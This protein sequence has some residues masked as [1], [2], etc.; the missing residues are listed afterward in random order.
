MLNEELLKLVAVEKDE[1]NAKKMAKTILNKH[2][3]DILVP[4]LQNGQSDSRDCKNVLKLL[5]TIVTISLSTFG[6][7]ILARLDIHNDVLKAMSKNQNRKDIFLNFFLSF[8]MESDNKIIEL[9]VQKSVWFFQTIVTNFRNY[10]DFRINILLMKLKENFLQNRN[11]SKSL[12]IQFFSRDFILQLLQID[13]PQCLDTVSDFL[14]IL[15]TTN[16]GVGFVFQN[17]VHNFYKKNTILKTILIRNR[18]LF[19]Q[20]WNNKLLSRFLLSVSLNCLDLTKDILLL[21]ESNFKQFDDHFFEINRF[22]CNFFDQFKPFTIDNQVSVHKKALNF[23]KSN[24]IFHFMFHYYQSDQILSSSL[25]L[26]SHHNRLFASI[27]KCLLNQLNIDNCEIREQFRSLAKITI[28]NVRLPNLNQLLQLWQISIEQCRVNEIAIIDDNFQ[29]FSNILEIFEYYINLEIIDENFFQETDAKSFLLSIDFIPNLNEIQTVELFKQCVKM[30]TKIS[31]NHLFDNQNEL[32]LF[33]FEKNNYDVNDEIVL[34]SDNFRKLHFDIW[35]KYFPK[36]ELF[37]KT[38]ISCMKK[39]PKIDF[40]SVKFTKKILRFQNNDNLSDFDN[41]I[42]ELFFRNF[43][44]SR[45]VENFNFNFKNLNLISHKFWQLFHNENDKLSFKKIKK[46]FIKNG[47]QFFRDVFNMKKIHFNHL[48]LFSNFL[49]FCLI[50][51]DKIDLDFFNYC[52]QTVFLSTDISMIMVNNDFLKESFQK[53]LYSLINGFHNN[54]QFLLKYLLMI[55][56]KNDT[57]SNL[58]I[59]LFDLLSNWNFFEISNDND[60][61]N[62]NS[63]IVLMDI[64]TKIRLDSQQIL[65]IFPKIKLSKNRHFELHFVSYLIQEEMYIFDDYEYL[66][67]KVANLICDRKFAINLIRFWM[68]DLKNVQ[69]SFEKQHLET[70]LSTFRNNIGED[71]VE[72]FCYLLKS[73]LISDDDCFEMIHLI[74]MHENLLFKLSLNSTSL[75]IKQFVLNKYRSA[76]LDLKKFLI[77]NKLAKLAICDALKVTSDAEFLQLYIATHKIE[78]V[79][80]FQTFWRLFNDCKKFE[81]C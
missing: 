61:D 81:R 46:F 3:N 2:F 20:F 26:K 31:K 16:K 40:D 74:D 57:L 71:V 32:L 43:H 73:N 18:E 29:Y 5:T 58:R 13:K 28:F 70:I 42:F 49:I 53:S 12:K 75:Q 67:D 30:I 51:I 24:V 77:S 78:I 17:D 37:S 10:D 39:F 44:C 35:L 63:L 14:E 54:D 9:L 80:T 79:S 23:Y 19:Q 4:I 1:I 68:K 7:D 27:L 21:C 69:N 60:T 56:E 36:N 47:P 55:F 41:A 45:F 59:I 34:N 64:V 50:T 48:E 72:F 76:I 62:N 33:I 52:Y 8:L 22:L 38:L 11:I 15:C 66:S 6:K 25:Q 65:Q